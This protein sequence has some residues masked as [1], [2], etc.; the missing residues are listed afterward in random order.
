MQIPKETAPPGT[1]ATA[2]STGRAAGPTMD[3]L[4]QLR[5][6]VRKARRELPPRRRAHYSQR[7]ASHLS[8]WPGLLYSKRIACYIAVDG[9]MDPAPLLHLAYE[10]GKSVYLPVLVPFCENRLWFAPWQPGCKM[11]P[12]RFGIPEPVTSRR[13]MISATALDLVLTPLVAFDAHCNRIGMGGGYYDRTFAFLRHRIHWR[14]PRLLG[15]A[16]EL[17]RIRQIRPQPWDVPL[18]G[19]ATE[20]TIYTGK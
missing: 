1:P 4:A 12:N 10:M 13:S 9:E 6:T 17:Q 2:G 14:K 5:A 18:H 7:L 20:E 11:A 3:N 19:V 8:S 15:I 16:Y